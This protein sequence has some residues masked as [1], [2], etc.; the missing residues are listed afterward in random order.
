MQEQMPMKFVWKNQPSGPTC[1]CD[2]Q[3]DG[4]AADKVCRPTHQ[5]DKQI[6]G[7]TDR[8]TD[9]WQGNTKKYKLFQIN[10]LIKKTNQLL[11]VSISSTTSRDCQL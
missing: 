9:R 10:R 2:K 8:W 1:Q 11:Q 4:Q 3:T 6:E 5:C 7:K